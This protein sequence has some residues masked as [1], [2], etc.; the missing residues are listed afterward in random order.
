MFKKQINIGIEQKTDLDAIQRQIIENGGK[1]T[2]MD[3]INDAISIFIN[4]YKNKAIL[5]YTPQFYD[6]KE[7]E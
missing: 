5:K 3:L 4:E 7:D 2:L 6:K 1:V